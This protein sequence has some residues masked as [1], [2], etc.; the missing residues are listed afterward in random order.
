ML[1]SKRQ[2]WVNKNELHLSVVVSSILLPTDLQPRLPYWKMADPSHCTQFLLCE[3]FCILKRSLQA[4]W[5]HL[6][7]VWGLSGETNPPDERAKTLWSIK[8]KLIGTT[9]LKSRHALLL[10]IHYL[11]GQFSHLLWK[12]LFR[13]S[14]IY[15]V[16]HRYEHNF[17]LLSNNDLYVLSAMLYNNLWIILN[18]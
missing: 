12:Q 17:T 9:P 14:F 7:S 10:N 13:D 2:V 15:H 5:R 6:S 4:P 8:G 3:V 11:S 16:S 18:I 1:F